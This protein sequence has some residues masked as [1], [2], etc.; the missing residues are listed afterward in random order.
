MGPT[1]SRGTSPPLP[2]PSWRASLS[3]MTTFTVFFQGV[4]EDYEE[5]SKYRIDDKGVLTTTRPD[6]RRR[7][8]SPAA[9]WYVEDQKP[10]RES[11]RTV[12]VGR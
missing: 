12:V 6:G 10:G 8:F 4:G 1:W 5:G 2:N 11:R 9:W 3:T 7:Q